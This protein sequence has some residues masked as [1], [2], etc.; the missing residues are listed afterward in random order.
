MEFL[1]CTTR[2][3]APDMEIA[4]TVSYDGIVDVEL[5]EM[6]LKFVIIVRSQI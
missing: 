3:V 4:K 6:N 2:S 5:L 1:Y